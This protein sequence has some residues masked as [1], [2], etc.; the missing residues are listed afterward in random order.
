MRADDIE[1]KPAAG[2]RTEEWLL[3]SSEVNDRRC[4]LSGQRRGIAGE[5]T[6]G[7]V[8]IDA[9]LRHPFGDASEPR[10][11]RWNVL[12]VR[13][14]DEPRTRACSRRPRSRPADFEEMAVRCRCRC[15]AVDDEHLELRERLR[16]GAHQRSRRTQQT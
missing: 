7:D 13:K 1:G 2:Q 5:L 16:D 15:L 8:R 10:H 6:P 12:G 3:E 9:F 14:S 11:G 4:W